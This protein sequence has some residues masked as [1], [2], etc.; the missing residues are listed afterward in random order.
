M[1][2]EN[3]L[4]HCFEWEGMF[5]FLVRNL[6]M[7]VTPIVEYLWLFTAPQ[8]YFPRWGYLTSFF[9]QD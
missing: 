9:N 1:V 2:Y 5:S 3:K 7:K 8:E 6:L 4:E